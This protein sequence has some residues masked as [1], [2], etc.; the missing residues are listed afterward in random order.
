MGVGSFRKASSCS[1]LYG[2]STFGVTQLAVRWNRWTMPACLRIS[3]MNCT[4]DAAEP[5]TAT[6]SPVRSWSQSHCAEWNI[7]PAKSRRPSMSGHERSLNIPIALTTMSA[8]RVAPSSSVRVHVADASSHTARCTP[9]PNRTW[10]STPYCSATCCMYARISGWVPYGFDQSGLTSNE[11]EYRA[12]CTS[13]SQPG[14]RLRFQVPPTPADFSSR[15]KSSMP[16]S[17]RRLPMQSPP[18]P[19]PM[20]ATWTRRSRGVLTETPRSTRS[21]WAGRYDR[22]VE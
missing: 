6:R 10:G 11:N 21:G 14:Y 19:A 22:T 3:G 8:V 4:A 2:V 7:G 17:S 20:T 16:S 12:D 13:H 18:G 9:L 1:S 5:M 15:T